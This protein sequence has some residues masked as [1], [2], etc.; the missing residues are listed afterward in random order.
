LSRKGGFVS[1][2]VLA[3]VLAGG[4]SGAF[5][6]LVLAGMVTNQIWLALDAAFRCREVSIACGFPVS[7][8]LSVAV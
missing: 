2:S 5:V 8:E 6:G 7:P 3:M 1:A 4:F